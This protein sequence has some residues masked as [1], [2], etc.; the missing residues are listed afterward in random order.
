LQNFLYFEQMK[1]ILFCL[2]LFPVIMHAQVKTVVLSKVKIGTLTCEN[3]LRI[4]LDRKDT[5]TDVV[6]SFQNKKRKVLDVRNIIFL[7]GYQ[8][9]ELQQ[10]SKDLSVALSEMKTRQNLDWNRPHYSLSLEDFSSS[11]TFGETGNGGFTML[12]KSD[13]TALVNWLHKIGF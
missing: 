8:G 3:S 11:L 2:F 9:E 13:V 5:T 6:F 12:Q 4:D 10:L 1:P 7:V